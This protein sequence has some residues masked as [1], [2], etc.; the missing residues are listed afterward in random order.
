MSLDFFDRI[1]LA[2]YILYAGTSLACAVLLL[3]G[4]YASRA[5]LLLWSGLCFTG[6]FLNAV[7]VLVDLRIIPTSDLSIWRMLPS[8]AGL[9]CLLYGM[10]WES[11]Q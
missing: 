11:E 4:Y 2:V 10:I 7:L 5:K 9:A 6:F 1:A 3:R 8:V